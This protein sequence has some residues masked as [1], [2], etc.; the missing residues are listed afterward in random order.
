[1][2]EYEYRY[3]E[4][5]VDVRTW[6]ITSPTQLTEQ[7]VQDLAVDSG[8]DREGEMSEDKETNIIVEY[9]GVDYGDDCQ[10]EIQGD[11]KED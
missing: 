8:F 3:I 10:T 5:S 1:M 9:E 11:T 2:S 6:K 7:E 4:Q